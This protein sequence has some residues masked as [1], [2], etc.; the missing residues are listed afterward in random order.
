MR[1]AQITRTLAPLRKNWWFLS[2]SGSE[3]FSSNPFA[4]GFEVLIRHREFWASDLA[5]LLPK[6]APWKSLPDSQQKLF[7]MGAE[8]VLKRVGLL[9]MIFVFPKRII[10]DC[11]DSDKSILRGLDYRLSTETVMMVSFDC[12]KK[13]SRSLTRTG[14]F[15]S[16]PKDS[17]IGTDGRNYF[18]IPSRL[19]KWKPGREPDQIVFLLTEEL[20]NYCRGKSDNK[21]LSQEHIH[22]A[23]RSFLEGNAQDVDKKLRFREYR[24]TRIAAAQHANRAPKDLNPIVL[25]Q[26]LLAHDCRFIAGLP[27][28]ALDKILDEETRSKSFG[29]RQ[30]IRWDNSLA[31]LIRILA[32]VKLYREVNPVFL[33]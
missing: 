9:K 23:F 11:T 14:C 18:K 20:N 30:R 25:A 26:G 5:R 8:P 3:E 13:S 22:A 10:F 4:Q 29:Q 16:F 17:G 12:A 33:K 31:A 2:G 28:S 1:S 15:P 21:V 7:S 27:L 6:N 32:K 19:H 24:K